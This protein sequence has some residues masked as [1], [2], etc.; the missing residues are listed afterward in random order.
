MTTERICS[1]RICKV[2][3]TITDILCDGKC[4]QGHKVGDSWLFER[5]MTPDRLCASA[6]HAVFPLV[7][8]LYYDGN[9]PMRS[10]DTPTYVSCPDAHHPVVF[11]LKKET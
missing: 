6:F 11:E 8:M 3:I 5:N 7:K 9:I 4:S 2:R 1:R 10:D